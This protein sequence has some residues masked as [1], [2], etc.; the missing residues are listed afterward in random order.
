MRRERKRCRRRPLASETLFD[1]GVRGYK[2]SPCRRRKQPSGGGT[3]LL[4]HRNEST[5][6]WQ[7]TEKIVEKNEEM[8]EIF[9]FCCCLLA[10]LFIYT[11]EFLASVLQS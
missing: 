9:F 2:P 5:I 3:S 7:R 8:D 11:G 6:I 1:V 4:E 10:D